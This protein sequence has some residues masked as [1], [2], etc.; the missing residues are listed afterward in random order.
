MRT[1]KLATHSVTVM[2]IVPLL[3]VAAA[4]GVP[5]LAAARPASHGVAA[6]ATARSHP[7]VGNWKV[8]Y[9]APAVVTMSLSGRVYT[10]TAKTS[11]RVVGSSCDLPAGTVIA[12]FHS[13]GGRTYAGRHGLWSTSNCSFAQWTKWSLKLSRNGR[14]LTGVILTTGFTI[15]F[16]KIIPHH[17]G[18]RRG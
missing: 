9:G 16:T 1:P 4:S 17:A 2:A 7:V 15:R 11:L 18:P 6:S 12:T 8:T 13:T 3:A 10:E 5:A 14:R